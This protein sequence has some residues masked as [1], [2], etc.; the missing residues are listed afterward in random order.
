MGKLIE[1]FRKF[2]ERQR[3]KAILRTA[4]RGAQRDIREKVNLARLEEKA[5]RQTRK[6]KALSKLRTAQAKREKAEASI[7]RAR[8]S[9]AKAEAKITRAQI[10]RQP[11]PAIPQRVTTGFTQQPIQQR[12]V[13]AAL[14]DFGQR[15]VQVPKV[16]TGFEPRQTPTSLKK[17]KNIGLG[18]SFRVL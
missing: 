4:K 13:G 8:A 6:E 10:I 17:K 3:E 7:L 2:K 18:T 12:P 16:R 1:R 14:M 11:R 5:E 15:P 9:R